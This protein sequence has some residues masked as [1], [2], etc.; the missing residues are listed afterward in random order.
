VQVPVLAAFGTE[1]R[2]HHMRGADEL[3][4]RA[5]QGSLAVVEG[6]TH[7]AHLTHPAAFADLVRRASSLAAERR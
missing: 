2:P 4:R 6:A 1:T 7:G 5:P 3:A